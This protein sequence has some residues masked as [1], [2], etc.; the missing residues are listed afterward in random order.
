MHSKIYKGNVVHH[1]LQPHQHR[2]SYRVFMMYLD[3]DELPE[4]FQKF[5]F[6]SATSSAIARF[7]RSDHYGNDVLPLSDCIRQL[8][9]EKT[10]RRPDGAISLL[11]HLRYFGYVMNPVSF[12]YCWNQDRTVVET[13][14]AEVHNT[15]WGEQH[16]Y[17]MDGNIAPKQTR[18]YEFDKQ[19]HVSPFMGMK[20]RYAWMFDCPED[21]LNVSMINI[22]D[23]RR[24]FTAIL[25]LQAEA[26]SQTSLN[27]V[28]LNY[29]MM[30]FKVIAAIYWQAMKL[31]W[32]KTPF[33]EHP[34]RY[35]KEGVS[36]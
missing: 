8:V 3:L 22:E 34:K 21:Q 1:R 7:K 30:T 29:P 36:L 32:K 4:L 13:V 5:R 25:R 35:S 15:P 19:F 10:G 28:L 26:I 23:E 16:C 31:W 2:F 9:E 12:Y 18:D 27:K 17:V 14:V 33:Y 11:T 6:W 20:Q 24:I